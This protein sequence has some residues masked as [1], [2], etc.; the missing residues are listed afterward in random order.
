MM[1]IIHTLQTQKGH[2]MDPEQFRVFL[3]TLLIFS[4]LYGVM[5]K[6]FPDM[7]KRKR[8]V[9][10][11]VSGAALIVIGTAISHG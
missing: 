10:L 4:V 5:H 11:F 7:D 9:I 1:D 2:Y 8:D 6:F 3:I